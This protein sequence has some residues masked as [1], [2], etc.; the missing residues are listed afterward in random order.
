MATKGKKSSSSKPKAKETAQEGAEGQNPFARE[1][2]GWFLF[3]VSAIGLAS[4]FALVGM[5]RPRGDVFGKFAAE[6][7]QM[8]GALPAFLLTL[9]GILA[10]LKLVGLS[11]LKIPGRLL[12]VVFLL[13]VEIVWLMSAGYAVAGSTTVV[14]YVNG[15]GKFGRFLMRVVAVPLG[16]RSTLAPRVA[17]A[18]ALFFTVVLGFRWSPTALVERIVARLRRIRRS[19]ADR[20]EE[21][22]KKAHGDLIASPAETAIRE[23]ENAKKT[24]A[25]PAPAELPAASAPEPASEPESLEKLSYEELKRRGLS[26]AEIRKIA[27]TR[28]DKDQDRQYNEWK[29]GARR[30]PEPLPEPPAP[31]ARNDDVPEQ[32][33]AGPAPDASGTPFPEAP[34]PED[35]PG[36]EP[37]G[38]EPATRRFSV[39]EFE[40]YNRARSGGPEP[41]PAPAKP[42]PAPRGG[43]DAAERSPFDY[44][45]AA[46]YRVPEILQVLEEP[47]PQES[48]LSMAQLDAIGDRIVGQLRSFR[49]DGKC[50]SKSPGPV[51]TCYEISLA[52][53]IPVS[54][55]AE[56]DREIAMAAKVNSVRIEAP[57]PGKDTIGIEVP[58]PVRQIVYFRDIL[59]DAAWPP[60]NA[61]LPVAL[62]SGTVGQ[63]VVFDLARA[64]HLLIGGSTGSGK[65]VCINTILASL[66]ALQKPDDLRLILV[67]PKVVELSLYSEIP[68]LLTPVITDPDKTVRM[69]EW[70]CKEMDDRYEI[71][72][73]G[74]VRELK[75]FNEKQLAGEY[76]GVLP[77]EENRKLERI[78]V[79][80]DE[81]ADIMAQ[82]GKEFEKYVA[83]IAAKAR[84]VGIHLVLATQRPDAKIIT[85]K[86]KS[87][88]PSRIAFRTAQNNDSRIILGCGGAEKL[89]GMGDMLFMA[90]N[91]PDVVRVHGCFISDGDVEKILEAVTGQGAEVSRFEDFCNGQALMPGEEPPGAAGDDESGEGGDGPVDKLFAQ[92]ARDLLASGGGSISDI[93]RTYN[94]GFSRAGRIVDQLVRRGVLGPQNNSSKKRAVL[95]S[96]EQLEEIVARLP[97]GG[98]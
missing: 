82:T 12:A 30:S 33:P 9:W 61:A 5:Q 2:A 37:A 21:E 67:D 35:E 72:A 59:N 24:G 73:R 29:F 89:L 11:F 27:E 65:S 71:L 45:G 75:S 17:G 68:H 42:A 60:K 41:E 13:W 84:A 97:R 81:F 92:I 6:L 79:V 18:V 49:V 15:G 77:P 22:L 58:N 26:D 55:A 62:G 95:V 19:A 7:Q 10:G 53:G 16:G 87:N 64:P 70:L 50:V 32:V 31:P 98:R 34:A 43:A 56:R 8:F 85:G 86:I 52:P 1:V 83:R 44:S 46:D 94:V 48:R 40:K 69:L 14:D 38:D 23:R 54:R 63:H 28:D 93:Q 90:G 4:L 88:L 74:R 57:I 25:Q 36:D 51:I 39:G 76:D 66:L 3:I 78:V 91:S 96:E 80:I 47:P 20:A